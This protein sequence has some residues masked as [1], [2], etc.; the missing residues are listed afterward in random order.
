MAENKGELM[1]QQYEDAAMMPWDD[2]VEDSMGGGRPP[3]IKIAYPGTKDTPYG[4]DIGQF[5]NTATGEVFNEHDQLIWLASKTGCAM[6]HEPFDPDEPLLCGSN[7]GL[8]PSGFETHSDPQPGPCRHKDPQ[9]HKWTDVCPK[10]AW[11]ANR[12]KPRCSTT[13]AVLFW[14]PQ[15]ERLLQVSVEGTA[16]QG[17]PRTAAESAV[18]GE[19][20]QGAV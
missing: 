7:D 14:A 18:P 10:L 17:P 8:V 9:T 5:F 4:C 2:T 19:D 15:P 13:Y 12:E 6:F 3:L 20:D 1:S 16:G 11:G